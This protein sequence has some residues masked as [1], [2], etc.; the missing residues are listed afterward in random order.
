MGGRRNSL[1][2]RAENLGRLAEYFGKRVGYY[3]SSFRRNT[4]AGISWLDLEGGPANVL[5]GLQDQLDLQGR[6]F[7]VLPGLQGSDRPMRE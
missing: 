5:L 4:N 1:A 2:D 3:Y 7:G 6:P